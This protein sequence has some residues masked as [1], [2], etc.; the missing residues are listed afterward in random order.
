[1]TLTVGLVIRTSAE[2][3]E[4]ASQISDPKSPSYR[5]YFTPEQFADWFGATQAD[6]QSIVEWAKSNNLTVTTHRNRFVVDVEGSV[7]DIEPA[8]GVRLNNYLRADGTVFFALDAEPS[9]AL[10]VPVEHIGGL[11]NF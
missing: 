7:A 3:I 4:T 5:K 6:Y 9:V 10:S 2:L 11:D 1:M 8:L